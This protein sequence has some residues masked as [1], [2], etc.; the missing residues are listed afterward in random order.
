MGVFGRTIGV[1]VLAAVCAGAALAHPIEKSG[2]REIVRLQGNPGEPTGA[3]RRLSVMAL[4]KEHVFAA[5]ELRVFGLAAEPAVDS[6]T[7]YQLQGSREDLFRFASAR[8][9]QRVTLL[10]ER[11]RGSAEL[12]VLAVDLCP[13]E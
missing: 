10:A 12:F 9:S 4:G 7:T 13:E 5:S 8:P 1:V 6:G 2:E 3:Q 11:R